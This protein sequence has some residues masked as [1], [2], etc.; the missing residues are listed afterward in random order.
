MNTAL[1]PASLRATQALLD[2]NILLDVDLNATEV[3][4]IA[5]VWEGHAPELFKVRVDAQTAEQRLQDFV[6]RAN[7]SEGLLNQAGS[8]VTFYALSLKTDG[9]PVEV[10]N[11][12]TGFNLV[13]GTNVSQEFLQHAVDALQP[14]PRG[15]PR[16]CWQ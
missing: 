4:E 2:A 9:M 3:G 7:L 15:K 5:N 13:Y 12:D 8:G 6:Q 10:V 11:S 16:F 1:V 14:Y